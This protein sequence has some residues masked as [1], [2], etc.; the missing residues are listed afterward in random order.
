[1]DGN[2]HVRNIPSLQA[3]LPWVPRTHCPATMA[4]AP[5][6]TATKAELHAEFTS[7]P[8]KINDAWQMAGWE[9]RR[10]HCVVPKKVKQNFGSK[11][12]IW[13]QFI[14]LCGIWGILSYGGK[15]LHR[16]KKNSAQNPIFAGKLKTRQKKHPKINPSSVHRRTGEIHQIRDP[17]GDVILT[18][19]KSDGP[20][21]Q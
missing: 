12:C 5:C 6:T 20:V 10:G 11:P 21:V 1:M 18:T 4:D 13:A 9:K 14:R 7:N 15:S 17:R 19:E 8:W 3:H 16:L 2:S